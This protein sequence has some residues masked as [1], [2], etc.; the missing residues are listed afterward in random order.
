MGYYT[1]MSDTWMPETEKK[2]RLGSVRRADVLAEQAISAGLV[3]KYHVLQKDW[4]PDFTDFTMRNH[5]VLLRI[6]HNT[7]LEGSG[8][9]W[10][11]TL[12]Q[13]KVV[14]GVHYN[15]ELEASAENLNKLREIAAFI[16]DNFGVTLDLLRLA[17]IDMAYAKEMGITKH[18]MY[19]EKYRSEYY[20][21]QK[22]EIVLAIDELPETAG[23]FA[24]IELGKA[25]DFTGWETRLG[26]EDILVETRDYGEIVKEM[27]K[28]RTLNKQRYLTFKADIHRNR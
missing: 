9:E 19:M 11:I 22:G 15:S 12:K 16:D 20:D 3:L 18:R 25:A 5:K 26:L 6:R 21:A 27:T 1:S 7:Y 17:H 24:E 14:D 2:Y 23:W 4:V 8:P 10:V 28:N 13:K